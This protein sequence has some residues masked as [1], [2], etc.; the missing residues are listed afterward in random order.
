MKTYNIRVGSTL[1]I[2]DNAGLDVIRPLA[3]KALKRGNE[4]KW[5]NGVSQWVSHKVVIDTSKRGSH[6]YT[7]SE[8][9][10]KVLHKIFLFTKL[11]DKIYSQE[12]GKVYR[13]D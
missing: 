4:V 12:I 7:W 2:C 3:I 10:E 1:H 13:K 8:D 11:K 9:G 5:F 6:I